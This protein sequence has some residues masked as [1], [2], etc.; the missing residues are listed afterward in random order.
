[1][2]KQASRQAC[3]IENNILISQ[4]KHV[5]GTFLHNWIYGVNCDPSKYI[6]YHQNHYCIRLS[7]KGS[8]IHSPGFIGPD[9]EFF[10]HKIL[11]IFL[12]IS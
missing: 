3:V 4:P 6:M 8:H 7:R 12:F 9:K 11:I 2:I 10:L 1:M 5:V